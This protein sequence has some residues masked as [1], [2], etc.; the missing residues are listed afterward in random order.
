MNFTIITHVSHSKENSEFF[1]YGPY[2]REMNIWLK[3]AETVTIVA[4]IIKEKAGNIDLAYQHQNINFQ[5][6]PTLAFN[7]PF[8]ILKSTLKLPLV[9]FKIFSAMQYADHIHLR[10]PGNIGLIGCIAQIFFPKKIKTAKYA[11]NWDLKSK[12]PWTYN[13]QK[14]ILS[15]TFLT[16]NMQVLVYG[17]WLKQS[18]NVKPFFTATYS[19]FEREE[20]KKT[21]LSLNADFI[22]V[23]SLVKGKNPMYALKLINK[24]VKKGINITFD[25]YGEGPERINLENYILENQLEKFVFLHGN[26]NQETVKKAYKKS[27]FVILPSKSEGWPKAI[28]EGMFWGSVPIATNVSCVSYMLDNGKRGILLEMN[29]E[30]DLTQ[31]ESLFIDSVRFVNFSKLAAEWSQNYTTEIFES[32][33][34]KLFVR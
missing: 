7:T 22:F 25:I 9:F 2:I 11:G 3:N 1:G 5:E 23:G 12:Q 4:P 6:I 33:I 10:C 21:D 27:H 15:N 28:A 29:L 8:N 18:K 14:Y 34:K 26:Q 17:E 24:L 20:V 32:E 16:R 30:K 31:I 19:N 13:L